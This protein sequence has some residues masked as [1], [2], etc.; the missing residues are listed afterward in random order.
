MARTAPGLVQRLGQRVE[1]ELVAPG[2][3]EVPGGVDPHAGSPCRQQPAELAPLV[4]G[5]VDEAG[6]DLSAVDDQ[7]EVLPHG[8]DVGTERHVPPPL[9]DG[10]GPVGVDDDRGEA[11]LQRAGRQP[12]L[13]GAAGGVAHLEPQVEGGQQCG[14]ERRRHLGT[15]RAGVTGRLLGA[16]D[17]READ[18]GRVHPRQ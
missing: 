17:E 9:P 13:E 18:G 4:G 6:H 11:G 12:L 15:G 1:R 8:R 16:G 3:D 14:L 7:V 10:G 2:V 5:V